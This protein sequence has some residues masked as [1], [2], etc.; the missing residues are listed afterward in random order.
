MIEERFRKILNTMIL[1][2]YPFIQ[3]VQVTNYNSGTEE[4]PYHNISVYLIADYDVTSKLTNYERWD[5][6]DYV[7]EIFELGRQSFTGEGHISFNGV[8]FAR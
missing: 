3:M 5:L 2:K 1:R 7:R 4:K 6:F 8:S